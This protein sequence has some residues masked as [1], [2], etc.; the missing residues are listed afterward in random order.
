MIDL[1]FI[2]S[3]FLQFHCLIFFVYV[4]LFITILCFM[5]YDVEIRKNLGLLQID[6]FSFKWVAFT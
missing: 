3:I 2:Y 1:Y 6:S 5:V 4:P